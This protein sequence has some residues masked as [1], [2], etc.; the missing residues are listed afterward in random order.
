[1]ELTRPNEN[2]PTEVLKA[3]AVVIGSGGGLAA[4]AAAAEKGVKVI[5]LEKRKKEGGN[6]L[7]ARGLMAAESPAQKRMKID[8]RR[9]EL[10]RTAMSYAHWNVNPRIIK[11][12]IDRSGDTVRWF[13][14][15]G[16]VF[17]EIPHEY[18]NQLPRIYHIPEGKGLKLVEVLREKCQALG[19]EVLCGT[20]ATKILMGPGG[21]VEGVLANRNGE[22][23]RIDAGSV[24]IATGGYSGNKRMLKKYYPHYSDT[25]KLYGKPNTGDGYD[26][27][28]EAGADTEGLGV[29]LAMGPFFQGALYVHAVTME[30]NTVWVNRLG[31]RFVHEDSETPSETANALNR[32]PGKISYALFDDTIRKGFMEYGLMKA[33]EASFP[34]MTKMVELERYL[35]KEVEKGHAVIASDWKKI[36][37]WVGSEDGRL[38]KT[39]DEYNAYCRQGYDESFYKDRRYLQPLVTP[40][41]YALK[42]CQAFHGTIGGIKI[43]HRMQVLDHQ[44]RVIPGLFAI[45]ND[46]GGWV[47]GTYYFTLT[48]TAL[49]FALTS[50]RIAGENI[51]AFIS[52]R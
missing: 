50:G 15:M 3:D 30:P 43:N 20:R 24:V 38:E 41:F 19:V 37:R 5:V 14:E 45:G 12:L 18:H 7:M 34:A 4:A 27:A 22:D 52:G 26:M 48:G 17:S 1:M 47:A 42:C 29:V 32:Q 13:E 39:V 16:V 25:L 2:A 35:Q 44:D 40:P 46:A 36:A 11:A 23:I 28:V 51:S 31:E 8:A 9:E 49:A 21:D 10:F 6:I 33:V